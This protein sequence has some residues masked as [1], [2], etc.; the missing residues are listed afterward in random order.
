M[1]LTI[2]IPDEHRKAVEDFLDTIP[3]AAILEPAPT[4]EQRLEGLKQAIEQVNLAKQGKVQL[5]SA[6]QLLDEL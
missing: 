3:D 5:K 2:D 6:Q 1:V 4:R